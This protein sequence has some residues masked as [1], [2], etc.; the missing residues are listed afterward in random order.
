MPGLPIPNIALQKLV[1][2]VILIIFMHNI[3]KNKGGNPFAKFIVGGGGGCYS[4]PWT[5]RALTIIDY[6]SRG[7]KATLFFYA[8]SPFCAFLKR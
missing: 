6:W 3:L 8:P 4:E 1:K 2:R 5:V 7:P